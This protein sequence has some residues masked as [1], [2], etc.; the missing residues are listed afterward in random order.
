M[1]RV[2]E[3][4]RDQVR[5]QLLDA[6]QRCLERKGFQST[7]TR[8]ILNEAEMSAGALYHYFDSKDDLFIALAERTRKAMLVSAVELGD[9]Q[10]ADARSVLR[11]LLEVFNP[12]VGDEVLRE[13][14]HRAVHDDECC[15][16][17]GRVNRNLV[18][19][20]VPVVSAAQ[21][22]GLVRNDVSARAL[23]EL[24]ATLYDG[25][26][27]RNATGAFATSFAELTETL[28]RVLL[29]GMAAETPDERELLREESARAWRR[30]KK[31]LPAGL[32]EPAKRKRSPR[33]EA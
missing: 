11:L 22:A 29:F 17:I 27:I 28:L 26:E 1:P 24:I 8:D 7:T 18:A 13:L 5:N 3:Q 30:Y 31:G 32:V 21:D 12:A 14:R 33:A 20:V 19:A 9:S 4:Y 10:V 2:S 16:A 6:A 25:F 15:A 23:V